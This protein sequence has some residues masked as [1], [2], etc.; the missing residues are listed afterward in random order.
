MVFSYYAKVKNTQNQGSLLSVYDVDNN[1]DFDVRGDSLVQKALSAD[2]YKKEVKL[3]KTK[4]AEILISSHNRPLTVKFQK[5]NGTDRVLRGRLVKPEPLLGRSM[6]E[7]LD[8][9]KGNPLRQVDHRTLIF[10]IV[11]GVKYIV[12]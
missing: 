4:V 7:D 12:K 11:D 3:S 10:L 5:A 2:R 8:I 1:M 6:V 9:T